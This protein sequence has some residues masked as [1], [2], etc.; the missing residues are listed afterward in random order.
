M[1]KRLSDNINN[2]RTEI[3][4]RLRQIEK[5]ADIMEFQSQIQMMTN[6]IEREVLWLRKHIGSL[7]ERKIAIF[8]A[9]NYAQRF[10]DILKNEHNITA[11]FFIDNNPALDGN[12]IHEKPVLRNPWES[13]DNFKAD[14][15]I[16]ISTSAANYRQIAKQLDDVGVP[17]ISSDTFLTVHLWNRIKAISDLL[18]NDISKTSYL[19]LI[20][21]YLT[22]ELNYILSSSSQYFAIKQFA[23]SINETICDVGAFVGDVTEEYIRRGMGNCIIYAF[24]P[25]RKNL[26]ALE[27]RVH[28]I[29]SEW[30]LDNDVIHIVP[31][32]VGREEGTVCFT[33]TGSYDSYICDGASGG[34]EVRMRTIDGFFSDKQLPTLIKVDKEG[35]E[36]D[37][38]MG[39]A[40]TIRKEK[41][42]LAICIYHKIYDAVQIPEYI[43]QICPEYKFA[44]RNHT[45]SYEETVLY[46][47]I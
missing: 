9:G 29:N 30:A 46:C 1:A 17:Y 38:L 21:Y 2:A 34:V 6:M 41:P 25:D 35:A 32:C 28:R 4:E 31:E 27:T 43:H 5:G 24:E 22:Y 26:R 18:D 39:A 7:Y 20:W 12:K 44:V 11:E 14:Y 10:Y 23:Q 45:R 16:L 40:D 15:F 42:K 13:I 37:L 19:G 33:E 3:L 36:I 47:W 8:S